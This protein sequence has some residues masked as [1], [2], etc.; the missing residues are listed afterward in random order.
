MNQKGNKSVIIVAA[1]KNF[2][3]PEDNIYLPLHVGAAGKDSIGYQRDDE[4]D[5]ISEKNPL[6]C[7]LTGLYWVW[8]NINADYKGL[9]HY[10]R[11][12][13]GKG[14]G[15]RP[16]D[17]VLSTKELSFL[18]R[19]YDVIVPRK[20]RY[21]IETLYSHYTHTHYE[22]ELIE[23]R[24]LIADKYPQYL[25]SFDKTLGRTWGYMF[26]MMIMRSDILDDYCM[27]VFDILDELVERIDVSDRS[28]FEKRFPGR[29][30]ELIFN[31]WLDY[32]IVNGNIKKESI[33]ELPF[34]YMEKI[35]YKAKVISFLKAKFLHK[36]QEKSF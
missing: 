30:S 18:T 31:T 19:R 16:F 17:K 4:G 11:Y 27:W 24:K 13:K 3:M 23:T 10:R 8:K 2:E 12:F 1:H 22:E 20:R 32:M 15:K 5:N 25:D 35:D 14:E 26:N 9:V 33:A 28:D 34:I 29:I 6:Y 36:K 7:E 21:Y